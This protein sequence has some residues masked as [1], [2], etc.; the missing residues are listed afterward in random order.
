ME[1]R[2]KT[3]FTLAEFHELRK[4]RA[5]EPTSPEEL[6]RRRKLGERSVQILASQAPLPVS[7]EELIRQSRR[8]GD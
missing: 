7:A 5:T 1:T 8:Y 4:R 6:E 2:Q 3:S